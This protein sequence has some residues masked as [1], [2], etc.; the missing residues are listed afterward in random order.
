MNYSRKHIHNLEELRYR[1]SL[2]LKS[3]HEVNELNAH[4]TTVKFATNRFSVMND[5]EKNLILDN[6]REKLRK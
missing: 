5:E 2:Y 6:N 3:V 1:E 4:T